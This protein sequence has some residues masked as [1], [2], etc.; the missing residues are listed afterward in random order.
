M[1][2]DFFS[3]K[4]VLG[5]ISFL[6][7]LSACCWFYYHNVSSEVKKELLALEQMTQH[8]SKS[9]GKSDQLADK[10]LPN[11]SNQ[12]KSPKSENYSQVKA[13][14]AVKKSPDLTSAGTAS[15]PETQATFLE[16][17]D[18]KNAAVSPHGLGPYPEIPEGWNPNAFDGEMTIGQ[19]LIERVR[20]KMFNEGIYTYGGSRDAAT[21]L[22][23]PI[24]RDRVY[25]R[26]GENV[27]PSL[28]R[29]R[30]AMLVRGHPDIV[31]KIKSNARA[32]S[33]DLP[34]QL[35]PVT[36][37]DIPKGVKVLSESDGIDPYD[38]LNLERQ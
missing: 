6:I 21:G 24:T 28:G 33:S 9:D 12:Q 26:W 34:E 5:S 37:D 7:I 4:W 13:N 15:D 27:F 1:I 35:R 29:T 20:I 16:N 11:I 19:E 8:N 22:V 10:T 30:Y 17:S 18:E 25:I 23:Y 3:N 38:F 2:G 31:A 36:E 14:D 32:R